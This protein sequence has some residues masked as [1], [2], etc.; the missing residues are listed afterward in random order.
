M[1]AAFEVL[2][3]G[4]GLLRELQGVWACMAWIVAARCWRGR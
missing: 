3:G 2:K 1:D 4:H